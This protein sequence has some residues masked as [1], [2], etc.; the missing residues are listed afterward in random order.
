L[1]TSVTTDGRRPPFLSTILG[2]TN[3][4]IAQFDARCT[5]ALCSVSHL[6]HLCPW[7]TSL[8]QLH[9]SSPLPSPCVRHAVDRRAHAGVC[10]YVF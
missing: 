5:T 8:V 6:A 9:T 4:M 1:S 3:N 7:L 10:C 2:T